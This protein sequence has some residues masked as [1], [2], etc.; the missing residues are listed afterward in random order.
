MLTRAAAV[1]RKESLE[2]LR[3]NGSSRGSIIRLTI[4]VIL[5]GVIGWQAG[6]VLGSSAILPFVGLLVGFTVTIPV[7]ADSFAGERERHTLEAMF[8]TPLTGFD[9]V[10]GKFL[11]S[12]TA[13]CICIPVLLVIVVC[14]GAM[15]TGGQ[16]FSEHA[17]PGLVAGSAVLSLGTA[18]LL[19]AVGMQVSLRASSTRNALQ[20]ITLAVFC[21]FVIP[22]LLSSVFHFAFLDTATHI[23]TQMGVFVAELSAL[24]LFL[25]VTCILLA[26]NVRTCEQIRALGATR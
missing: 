14:A 18:A 11:A 15:K 16:L 17:L 8:A 20:G 25:T 9:I 10:V 12:M 5:G 7:V 1:W 23:V 6:E 13:A 21:L 24:A 2:A 4:L 3:E 26:Y 19:G 22:R